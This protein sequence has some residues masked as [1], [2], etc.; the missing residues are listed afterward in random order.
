M[1]SGLYF[2][3]STGWPPLDERCLDGESYWVLCSRVL[4]GYSIA[5]PQVCVCGLGWGPLCQLPTWQSVLLSS[6]PHSSLH[7]TFVSPRLSHQWPLFASGDKDS[8]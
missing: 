4:P 7:P 6:T 5:A 3:S 1:H 8:W 2:V